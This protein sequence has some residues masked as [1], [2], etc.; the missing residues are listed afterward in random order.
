MVTQVRGNARE[1]AEGQISQIAVDWLR[2][3]LPGG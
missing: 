1:P 2:S 3:P